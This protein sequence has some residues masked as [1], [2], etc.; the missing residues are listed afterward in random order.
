VISP[1]T[2]SSLPDPIVSAQA[3]MRRGLALYSTAAEALAQGNLDPGN[4][5]GLIEGQ[6][7]YEM[8]AQ[9]VRTS[10]EMLGTLLDVKV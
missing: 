2:S 4:V 10:D 3:G 7:T 9:V 5:I 6:R 1:L 8:N